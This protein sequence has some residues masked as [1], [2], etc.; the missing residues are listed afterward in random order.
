MVK[1]T[2][3]FEER[4]RGAPAIGVKCQV[5]RAFS[6]VNY[7]VKKTIEYK[8]NNNFRLFTRK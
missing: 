3:E 2:C 5:L 4:R 1:S 8:K 7:E 6:Q